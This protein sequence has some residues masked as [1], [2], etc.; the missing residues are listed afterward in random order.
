[1]TRKPG[2][3]P[4]MK[5]GDMVMLAVSAF[6]LAAA[7]AGYLYR[8]AVPAPAGLTATVSI[9]GRVVDTLRL[10]GAGLPVRRVYEAGGGFNTVYADENGAA[11]VEAD[12]PDQRCVRSGPINRPGGSVICLPHRFV[13][14]IEGAGDDELDGGTY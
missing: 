4:A 2:F 12:C 1:M 10:D 6:L 3:F 7:L 5:K 8:R 11:V 9:N 14:R 13:L